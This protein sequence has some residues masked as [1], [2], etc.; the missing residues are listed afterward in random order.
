MKTIIDINRAI[1]GKVKYFAT[2]RDVTLNC[3]VE[4]LIS[5]GLK[6]FG[7]SIQKNS[8]TIGNKNECV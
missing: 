7:F 6:D 2:V 1:W 3:A 8:G 5:S 4:L